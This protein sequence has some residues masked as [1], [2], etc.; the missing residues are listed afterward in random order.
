MD[1]RVLPASASEEL[2]GSV[3][4]DLVGVHV[5]RR[6]RATLIRST[7]NWSCSMPS[8]M[9]TQASA[10]ALDTAGS[11]ERTSALA[12][13]A[14]CFTVARA[15]IRC[16]RAARV[17]PAWPRARQQ[18][19]VLRPLERVEAAGGARL[20]LEDDRVLDPGLGQDE[21]RSG[22][23]L[24]VGRD[25][26]VRPGSPPRAPSVRRIGRYLSS[27]DRLTTG[28]HDAH[29]HG[30]PET[31]SRLGVVRGPGAWRPRRRAGVGLVRRV[32]LVR[33]CRW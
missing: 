26:P 2:Q 20:L 1:H 8:R 30:R 14:A 29:G 27:N 11:S 21:V 32:S 3:R 12:W 4:D 23:G 24:L 22:G 17:S 19:A 28:C 31:V 9:S 5:G 13:A 33:R 10:M 18:L 15:R 7:T 16:G 6:A 25:P